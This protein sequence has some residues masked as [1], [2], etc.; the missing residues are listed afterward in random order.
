MGSK[1]SEINLLDLFV[2]L[3]K[4]KTLVAAITGGVILATVI[5]SLILPIQ[6]TAETRLM[7]PPQ[8][9]GASSAL[10]ALGGQAGM[11]ASALGI[12]SSLG[13]KSPSD[14]F[15]A[16][17]KSRTIG[18][19]IID[20]FE[21][22]KVYDEDYRED[23]SKT[24]FRNVRVQI[25]KKSGII[26]LEVTDKDAKRAADMANAFV[27]E[28]KKLNTGISVSD[29]SQRRLFFENQ[30]KVAKDSLIKSEEDMKAFQQKTGAIDLPTQA[31]AV[32]LEISSIR[33]HIAAQE[34]QIK[35]LKTYA[36]DKNPEV[37]KA[38]RELSEMRQQ[39]GRIESSKATGGDPVIPTG[40]IASLG[41]DYTRKLRDL[42]TQEALYE[43]LLKQYEVAKVD[44]ARESS[45]IQVVDSA[46]VPDKKSSPK[47]FLMVFIAAFIG[48]FIAAGIAFILEHKNEFTEG[49]I[50]K[51]KL[52]SI[53]KY[54]TAPW[55][56]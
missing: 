25:D 50:N 40:A 29:A 42:K 44:E 31:D 16:E 38:E 9:L 8:G 33:A 18:D 43:I 47:R 20:R 45:V 28:L 39:L 21:L 48:F 2:V 12:G 6:Y 34:I 49:S 13:M 56:F 11:A 51:G 36:T 54:A 3:I 23:A 24:L 10:G 17:I 1:D 32:I 22:M 14:I 15:A 53:R 30:S 35:S 7:P 27:G 37:K 4:R 26:S 52:E 41:T 5:L 19:H 46:V 55:K